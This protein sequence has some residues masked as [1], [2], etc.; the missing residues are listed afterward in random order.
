MNTEKDTIESDEVAEA[1]R[2]ALVAVQAETGITLRPDDWNKWRPTQRTRGTI[3]GIPAG[4]ECVATDGN[5][6]IFIVVEAE[7]NPRCCLGKAF[8]GHTHRFEWA[9]GGVGVPPTLFGKP[10]PETT[11]RPQAARV[12]RRAALLASI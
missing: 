12:N 10:K 11:A 9:D 7:S 4:V 8:V 5:L 2:N 3:S 6:A 1:N